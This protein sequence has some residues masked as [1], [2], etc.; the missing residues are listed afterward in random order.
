MDGQ[1]IA[2][3]GSSAAGALP[4]NV[5][6]TLITNTDQGVLYS[7]VQCPSTTT[8]NGCTPQFQLT[9]VTNGSPSTVTTGIGSQPGGGP[10]QPILQR[11]DGSYIGTVSTFTGNQMVAFTSSGKQL[12][13]GPNDTPQITT[14]DG[15]VVGASGTTYDQNGIANGLA[16]ALGG[17]N[18]L[19]NPNTYSTSGKSI[20]ASTL[21]P[22]NA[23]Y[24]SFSP[25]AAGNPSNP[26]AVQQCPP[27]SP[28]ANQAVTQAYS[29][30]TT[31]LAN[32][33]N[34][35][36]CKVKIFGPLKMTRSDFLTYLQQTPLFCD[37]TQATGVSASKINAAY[38]DMTIAK[39][40]QTD[41]PSAVTVPNGPSSPLWIFFNP[42]PSAPYSISGNSGATFNEAMLFHEGL[43]GYTKRFDSVTFL[44]PKTLGLCELLGVMQE[45]PNCG[46]SN[47]V[48][49]TFFIENTAWPLR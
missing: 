44:A 1:S 37:G 12:W 29:G 7:W 49:I 23:A 21:L 35:P 10:V 48:V 5:L 20:I 27:L 45:Y 19:G 41:P 25:A 13:N 11:A 36:N 40:F 24:D 9:T 26:T 43:H 39:L 34:C 42:D 6:G 17:Y 2:Y 16:S 47:T 38:Q 3:G 32:T 33:N 4:G 30:L 46:P 31:F 22:L 18:W 28:S 14:S 8:S 15:G